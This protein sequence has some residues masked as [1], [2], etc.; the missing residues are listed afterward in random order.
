MNTQK[1]RY[2][3]VGG[4]IAFPFGLVVGGYMVNVAFWASLM[5]TE[6]GAY[7]AAVSSVVMIGF[8]LGVSLCPKTGEGQAKEDEVDSFY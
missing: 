4:L 5:G 2:G 7:K 3:I 1:L 6:W 8:A